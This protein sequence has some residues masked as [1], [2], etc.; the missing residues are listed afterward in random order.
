MFHDVI[1]QLQ[2]VAPDDD[3]AVNTAEEFY[4]HSPARRYHPTNIVRKPRIFRRN[5]VQNGF[6]SKQERHSQRIIRN[7][8]SIERNSSSLI[9]ACL[10]LRSPRRLA[11]KT[12]LPLA[13]FSRRRQESLHH[14]IEHDSPRHGI[15]KDNSH[16]HL[17]NEHL[18]ARRRLLGSIIDNNNQY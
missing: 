5:T 14:S 10:S 1:E 6:V 8:G 15:V 16:T 3:T 2:G 17:E 18:L 11:F 9:P 12:N 13:D 7:S 4:D